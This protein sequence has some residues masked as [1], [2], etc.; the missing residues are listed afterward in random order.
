MR[1][2][3]ERVADLERTQERYA[4]ERREDQ[5]AVDHVL[6]F[7][8][9][10][11]ALRNAQAEFF[12]ELRAHR[13]DGDRRDIARTKQLES[14]SKQ[15]QRAA[16]LPL[17]LVCYY[18]VDMLGGDLK[19]APGAVA[20][21]GALIVM[22]MFPQTVGVLVGRLPALGAILQTPAPKPANGAV[23]SAPPPGEDEVT[24][25]NIAAIGSAVSKRRD[26]HHH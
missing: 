14:L 11:T 15:T 7:D 16:A 17:A 19:G 20:L 2:L 5:R 6:S 1:T 4:L 24:S 21:G 12:A 26:T 9:S 3:P 8:Q 22:L 25:V 23:S 13:A 18:L 10:V